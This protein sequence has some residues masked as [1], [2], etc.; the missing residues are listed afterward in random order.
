MPDSKPRGSKNSTRCVKRKVGEVLVVNGFKENT[1][2][3]ASQVLE[4][5]EK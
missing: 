3:W 2:A 1:R 4:V 5:L